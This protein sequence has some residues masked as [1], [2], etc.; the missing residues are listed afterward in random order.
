[1][2]G[3]SISWHRPGIRACAY[4]RCDLQVWRRGPAAWPWRIFR[5]GPQ[6]RLDMWPYVHVCVHIKR[7]WDRETTVT[8]AWCADRSCRLHAQAQKQSAAFSSSTRGFRKMK[9]QMGNNNRWNAR[10]N[11]NVLGGKN[12]SHC[13]ITRCKCKL[14]KNYFQ[15]RRLCG[16]LNSEHTSTQYSY[17]LALSWHD[18]RLRLSTGQYSIH[19]GQ[20]TPNVTMTSDQK[21]MQIMQCR[22]LVVLL[23]NN[24]ARALWHNMASQRLYLL[25]FLA[26]WLDCHVNGTSGTYL[27]YRSLEHKS[28]KS[29]L[30]ATCTVASVQTINVVHVQYKWGQDDVELKKMLCSCTWSDGGISTY[31]RVCGILQNWF[32]QMTNNSSCWLSPALI[33]RELRWN[34]VVGLLIN[35]VHR[36]YISHG[37]TEVSKPQLL[38]SMNFFLILT[39]LTFFF[40]FEN[41]VFFLSSS[42]PCNI[43]PMG[44]ALFFVFL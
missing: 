8:C 14:L 11:H 37:L 42:I 18:Q 36:C 31:V 16:T 2:G 6:T 43:Y 3:W 30:E 44:L 39:H 21:V 1:M 7:L 35:T 10:A 20:R 38:H 41:G 27:R 13:P 33:W 24:Q 28:A 40:F 12:T 29:E 26:T 15:N 5:R 34:L 4:I 22:K 25:F 17:S 23:G 9:C 19:T 32:G